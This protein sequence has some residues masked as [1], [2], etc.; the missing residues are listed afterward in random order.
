MIKKQN[1]FYGKNPVKEKHE[2]MGITGFRSVK[3]CH[4]IC[5]TQWNK[6][7]VFTKPPNF[8]IHHTKYRSD[9]V[10]FHWIRNYVFLSICIILYQDDNYKYLRARAYHKNCQL[11]F[12]RIII[13][14]SW[15][16]GTGQE[17][18]PR[19]LQCDCN[20]TCG[21]LRNSTLRQPSMPVF[22]QLHCSMVS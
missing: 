4:K 16:H 19:K 8:P 15:T 21:R 20:E 10:L 2:K 17:C 12:P 1:C 3:L 11:Q 9:W 22:S 7:N 18:K 13:T 6:L 14:L 5:W